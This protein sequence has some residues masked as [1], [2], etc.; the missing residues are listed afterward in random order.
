MNTH[1]VDLTHHL[2]KKP[3]T[4]YNQFKGKF[5]QHAY[6]GKQGCPNGFQ[7]GGKAA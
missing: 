3:A 1:Q 4:S 7:N 5:T 6:I 2:M